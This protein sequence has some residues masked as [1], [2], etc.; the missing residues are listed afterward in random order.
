MDGPSAIG[1]A[2][3][4]PRVEWRETML[5][6]DELGVA[7]GAFDGSSDRFAPAL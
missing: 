4:R 1:I 5:D 3:S 2:G 6:A 7:V